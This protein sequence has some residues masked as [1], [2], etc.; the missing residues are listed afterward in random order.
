MLMDLAI[1]KL[2]DPDKRWRKLTSIGMARA[3]RWVNGKTSEETA[4]IMV[5]IQR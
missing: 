2:V 4:S 5:Y 1:L 3:E